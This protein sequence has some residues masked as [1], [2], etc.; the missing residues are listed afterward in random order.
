MISDDSYVFF[1]T[2]FKFYCEKR[3]KK[4]DKSKN[5][6]KDKKIGNYMYTNLTA[7]P[8]I[9]KKMQT[10]IIASKLFPDY[11]SDTIQYMYLAM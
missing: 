9:M 1:M 4:E 5:N 8:L 6:N 7:I 3:I 11:I 10:I 2:K